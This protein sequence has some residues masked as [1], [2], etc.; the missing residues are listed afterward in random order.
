MLFYLKSCFS[1]AQ[2]QGP[3]GP[4]SIQWRPRTSLW[5][6]DWP[7]SHLIWKGTGAR[8][9]GRG[10]GGSERR[11]FG[12][13]RSRGLMDIDWVGCYLNH[14]PWLCINLF[15]GKI[16][17]G[18][19]WWLSGKESACQCR[20]CRRHKF[21]PWIQES[22][23]RWNWQSTPV[24]LPGKSHGQSRRS[25]GHWLSIW[26]SIKTY[27]TPKNQIQVHDKALHKIKN[28]ILS[29]W[30]RTIIYTS[31][32]CFEHFNYNIYKNTMV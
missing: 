22:P 24:P 26:R 16:K 31:T 19:P 13:E 25:L 3:W 28:L 29:F 5:P 21:D 9:V 27:Q 11:D 4:R 8:V 32:L 10:E 6:L 7:S 2:C 1:L 14:V 23:W 20:R 12:Q 17:R 15:F 18:L 30:E